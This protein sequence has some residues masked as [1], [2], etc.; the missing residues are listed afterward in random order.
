MP[1]GHELGDTLH[2][3]I[4]WVGTFRLWCC[5]VREVSKLSDPGENSLEAQVQLG[6]FQIQLQGR[7]R[8]SVEGEPLLGV[9]GFP[10][11]PVTSRSL[12]H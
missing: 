4:I 12:P 10:L 8:N 9:I 6:C 2:Y 3:S 1:S 7:L 11:F 5:R